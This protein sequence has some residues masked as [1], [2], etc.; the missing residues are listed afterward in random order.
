MDPATAPTLPPYPGALCRLVLVVRE[1]QVLSAA[2]DVDLWRQQGLRDGRALDMPAGAA[3]AQRGGPE[4][5]GDIDA[6]LFSF[7][8]GEVRVGFF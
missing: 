4:G 7:P 3:A 1:L 6:G 8:E 5:G 2:V